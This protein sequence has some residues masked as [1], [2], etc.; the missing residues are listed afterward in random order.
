M[1]VAS[2][3][4]LASPKAKEISKSDSIGRMGSTCA[5]QSLVMGN[6]VECHWKAFGS[7]SQQNKNSKWFPVFL[8]Q[9]ES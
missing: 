6:T 5:Q 7:D 3:S 4:W 2:R 9:S 1:Q 8:S